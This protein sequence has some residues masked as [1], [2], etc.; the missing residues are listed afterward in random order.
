M[1]GILTGWLA[2]CLTLSAAGT[3]KFDQTTKDIQAPSDAKTVTADFNFKNES[4]EDVIIERYD[5][6]CTCINAQILDGK[7]V[8]KPGES[9]VIRAAF[10]MSTFSGTVD[11]SVAVWL[12]GDPTHKPSIMLTTRV[13]IP[14]LVEMEP[15]T[16]IWNVG[17][18]PEPKTITLTMKHTEPIRVKAISGADARFSQEI[19]TIEEGKKYEVVVTPASTEKVGMGVIHIETDCPIERH[20]SQRVFTV[21]RQPL[22]KPVQTAAKP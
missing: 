10:D 13:T 21:I 18:K 7:L 15:K 16:L 3:L 6:A 5:A 9:G 20:R 2:C 11:K 19:K 17:E 22:P 14:V 8:Y 12:K 1:K 4:S